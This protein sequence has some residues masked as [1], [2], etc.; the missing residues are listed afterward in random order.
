MET[1]P[2]LARR[3][4]PWKE[5][6]QKTLIV[7]VL[8]ALALAGT[9]MIT[10]GSLD[11]E[12]PYLLSFAGAALLSLCISAYFLFK[13]E[14]RAKTKEESQALRG[15]IEDDRSASGWVSRFGY[16]TR[17]FL[18]G[19]VV[20]GGALV[21]VAGIGVLGLQIYR[22][23]R[24]GE[25]ISMSLFDFLSPHVSWLGNPQSWFGLYRIVKGAFEIMP[26]SLAVILVGWLIA[27]FGSALR[28][29]VRR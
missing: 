12:P 10:D 6:L 8:T 4:I 25:W 23:L 9:W 5:R 29:R 17:R 3:E 18:A 13:K 27:G 21:V 14:E 22:Y 15:R 28:Q 7:L 16:S 2:L 26:L 19:M 11:N 1:S 24:V 20:L